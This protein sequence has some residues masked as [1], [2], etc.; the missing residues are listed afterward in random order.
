MSVKDDD[1]P[2]SPLKRRILAAIA[3][4]PACLL[5]ATVV[6]TPDAHAAP[7][8]AQAKNPVTPT[9]SMPTD[10]PVQP[11]QWWGNGFR[12]PWGNW[13]NWHNWPNWNNWHNW[14]NW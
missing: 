11:H 14:A 5:A 1:K 7:N 8:A 9:T 12:H 4:G 13:N 3:A 10:M 6:S 2:M